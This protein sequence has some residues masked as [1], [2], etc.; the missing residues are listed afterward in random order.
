MNLIKRICGAW[1]KSNRSSGKN[2]SADLSI[3]DMQLLWSCDRDNVAGGAR[4][5]VESNFD[6]V[7]R[8]SADGWLAL[9]QMHGGV[10]LHITR[11][12]SFEVGKVYGR[13]SSEGMTPWRS[14]PMYGYEL[15]DD[16]KEAAL[17]VLR[18]A[19]VNIRRA[20]M[21]SAI[22]DIQF[23][24]SEDGL[25]VNGFIVKKWEDSSNK[26]ID[27]STSITKSVIIGGP[28]WSEC[29]VFGEKTGLV[30]TTV[31]DEDKKLKCPI[32]KP[33]CDYPEF[34]RK[35]SEETGRAPFI[36]QCSNCGQYVP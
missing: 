28:Q 8:L 27:K 14:F 22:V 13:H 34:L 35:R 18:T 2:W 5:V 11:K 26:G 3:A 1:V 21:E 31:N 15:S 33:G 10:R 9:E 30:P 12:G 19:A 36:G 4:L 17:L 6:Q 32:G 16:T 7:M 23:Q 25:S 20:S 29:K 24:L